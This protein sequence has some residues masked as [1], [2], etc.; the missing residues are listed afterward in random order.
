MVPQCVLKAVPM[1]KDNLHLVMSLGPFNGSQT[2]AKA[3]L[4]NKY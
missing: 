4:T 1:S 2:G 3:A